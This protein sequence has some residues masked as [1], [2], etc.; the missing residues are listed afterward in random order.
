[1]WS[2]KTKTIG[3]AVCLALSTAPAAHAQSILQT[4]EN[5][6]AEFEDGNVDAAFEIAED[7]LRWG[8]LYGPNAI[9]KAEECLS[10]VTEQ[11]WTYFPSERELLTGEEA[12]EAR[13]NMNETALE[14][15]Q[16]DAQLM[17]LN[18]A[19]FVVGLDVERPRHVIE[20]Q[21]AENEAWLRYETWKACDDLYQTSEDHALLSPVCQPL[22]LS[23]GTPQNSGVED[24]EKYLFDEWQ[25]AR[26][27]GLRKEEPFRSASSHDE[28]DIEFC[29]ALLDD[30]API[31]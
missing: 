16:R 18:C 27:E 20:H 12:E 30:E 1:M 17:R 21:A 28:D 9:A 7:I 15:A 14:K 29:K 11:T 4:A 23:Y 8:E 24:I 26:I 22:F 5:C 31:E 25:L 3:A 10:T 19:E 6:I 2:R 13:R